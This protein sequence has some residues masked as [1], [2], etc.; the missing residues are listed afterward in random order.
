M[1]EREPSKVFH[2]ADLIKE[3]MDERGWTIGDLVM[4]MGPHFSETKWQ[5]CRLSWEMF[6]EI[7]EPY[8]VLDQSM[9]Q[10]LADAFGVNPHFFMNYHE[11]WRLVQNR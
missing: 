8:V 9:A 4:N 7:R 10:Q 3:E 11:A 5:I 2:L 6:F 1:S